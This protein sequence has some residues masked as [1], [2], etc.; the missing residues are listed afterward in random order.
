M[1]SRID[2]NHLNDHAAVHTS[3]SDPSTGDSLAVKW[4]YFQQNQIVFRI[5]SVNQV[6]FTV[7][8]FPLSRGS[9]L[10]IRITG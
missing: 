6:C 2:V 1:H 5:R 10:D 7:E 9:D 3:E 4:H 8:A